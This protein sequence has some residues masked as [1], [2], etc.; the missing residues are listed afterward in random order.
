MPYVLQAVWIEHADHRSKRCMMVDITNGGRTVFPQYAAAGSWGLDPLDHDHADDE[1]VELSKRQLVRIALIATEV[2][3]RF[4]RDGNTH[5]PM[6][7]ML[8]PRGLF[9]GRPAIE[10]CGE[11]SN[12]LRS[13]LV[14]GLGLD[15]NAKAEVIDALLSSDFD[16]ESSLPEPTDLGRRDAECVRDRGTQQM[17]QEFSMAEEPS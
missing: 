15:L 3:A 4:Q 16:D 1:T 17:R 5:D 9:A 11:H 6:A 10:A 14:H 12:C 8:V 7:W 2:G 13:I